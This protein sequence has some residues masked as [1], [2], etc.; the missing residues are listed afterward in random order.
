MKLYQ[1]TQNLNARA[2]DNILKGYNQQSIEAVL[3]GHMLTYSGVVLYYTVRPDIIVCYGRLY[4]YICI[5]IYIYIHTS[6]VV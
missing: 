2:V 5:Y 1:K 4:E 3:L 6:T